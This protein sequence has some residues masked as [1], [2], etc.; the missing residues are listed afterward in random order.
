MEVPGERFAKQLH[1]KISLT[2][3]QIELTKI[4]FLLPKIYTSF[5]TVFSKQ[6]LFKY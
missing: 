4:L 6:L 5:I 1:Y 3:Q 2:K